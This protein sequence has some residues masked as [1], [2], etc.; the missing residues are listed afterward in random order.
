[1]YCRTLR[2]ARMVSQVSMSQLYACTPARAGAE[3]SPVVRAASR[4]AVL[5][6]TLLA[7]STAG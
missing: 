4:L 2:R 6:R 5:I 1:V 7:M 3:V